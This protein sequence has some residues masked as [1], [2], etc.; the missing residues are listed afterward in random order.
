MHLK[1]L[2]VVVPAVLL[3]LGSGVSNAGQIIN[4]VGV[5]VCVNDKWEEK[6]PEKGYKLVDAAQRCVLIPDDP[7]AEKFTE[8]CVGKYEYKP[9]GSWKATG[10]CT[11][12]RP[13]GE[14]IFLSWEEGSHLK[15]YTITYTGGTGKYQGV[16]GSG[17]YMYENLTDNFS[18]G[19]YKQQLVLP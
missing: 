18:A 15:D 2:F 5:L 19:R 12:I 8:K 14:K 11:D 13:G 1:Q 4:E 16:T 7:G 10:T 17:T 3:T 9:D 6:E